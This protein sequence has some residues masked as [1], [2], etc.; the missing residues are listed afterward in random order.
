MLAAKREALKREVCA[1]IDSRATE[2]V[3]IGDHI[4]R[5][6][7][8]GFREVDTAAFV[9]KQFTR[10]GLPYRDMLALTGVKA[11]LPGRS[12]R[13]TIAV[14][15]ELDSLIDSRHPFANPETHAAHACCHYTQVATMLGAGMGLQ[16]VIGSLDGSV[17]LFAVPA[18]ECIEVDWR[19]SLRDRGKLEFIVGKAELIRLGEFDDI[20]VAI[21]THTPV[22][23]DGML[24]TVGDS[25]NGCVV[26]Y[27]QFIGRASHA[28]AYPNKGINAFK[29]ATVALG[30]IDAQRD[31][32]RDED[33]VRIHYLVS[34]GG[35]AVSAVPADVRIEMLVRGKTVEAMAD[36]SAKVDR[37]LRAGAHAL[38]AMVEIT[39]ISGYMPY[40]SD[41]T[42]DALARENCEAVVGREKVGRG[43]HITGS[44]D[45]GDLSLIMPVVQ[46]RSSGTVGSPHQSDYVVVDPKLAMINPAKSM[47]MMVIDLLWNGA[48]E[49]R[50]I[51]D[52]A[53]K[54]SKA[55]YLQMRRQFDSFERYGD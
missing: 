47:A 4:L 23:S 28:A 43:S 50:A 19:R 15:G 13:P 46:P 10:M 16:T 31:T 17:V 53:Q 38:G 49:A 36:A 25:H 30:A 45:N 2:I 3:E 37:C 24:A 55:E 52:G 51:M 34:K 18:E 35:E 22:R 40:H 6:P 41:P 48:R 12:E 32:F 11:R 8:T 33:R 27:I 54:L 44:T 26:K 29:A 14:M 39:T 9:C 20:D 5:H 21:M 1:A 7:E 42:L